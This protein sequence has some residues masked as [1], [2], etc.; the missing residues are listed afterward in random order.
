LHVA[1]SDIVVTMWCL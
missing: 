1:T